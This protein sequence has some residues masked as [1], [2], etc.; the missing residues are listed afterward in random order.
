MKSEKIFEKS[1]NLKQNNTNKNESTNWTKN[2]SVEEDPNSL[3]AGYLK[4]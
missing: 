3:W 1:P 2:Y 4:N